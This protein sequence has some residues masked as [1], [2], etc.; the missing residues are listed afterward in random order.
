META[1]YLIVPLLQ[2]FFWFDDGLQAYLR[3]RGWDHI[4]RRLVTLYEEVQ[5][6][7]SL[8]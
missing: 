3:S 1:R 8:R 7:H 6:A 5:R 2:A 4:T